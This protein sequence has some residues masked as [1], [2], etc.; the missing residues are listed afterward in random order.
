MSLGFGDKPTLKNFLIFCSGILNV[1][2]TIGLV[3]SVG[4]NIYQSYNQKVI[5]QPPFILDEATEMNY[6]KGKLKQKTFTDFAEKFVAY[7]EDLT[8]DNAS[9]QT[10]KIYSYLHPDFMDF[11]YVLKKRVQR[12]EKNGVIRNYNIGE[13]D[14]KTFGVIKIKGTLSQ[15]TGNTL[16]TQPTKRIIV[17]YY[18]LSI[19]NGFQILNVEY[20]R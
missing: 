9:K 18:D 1:L 7:T 8:P 15:I 19:T 3:I 14:V 10:K 4:L 12:L 2:L 6:K 11:K 20:K 5:M 17:I 13:I 16:I